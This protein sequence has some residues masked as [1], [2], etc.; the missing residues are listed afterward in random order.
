[1]SATSS[2]RNNR[3]PTAPLGP[4][5]GNRTRRYRLGILFA[6]TSC[7]GAACSF[8]PADD[9]A[10]GTIDQTTL[11]AGSCPSDTGD[12]WGALGSDPVETTSQNQCIDMR[13]AIRNYESAVCG[14]RCNDAHC[15][16]TFSFYG[17]IGGCTDNKHCFNN[18]TDWKCSDKGNWI[19]H[20]SET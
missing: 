10:P 11:A 6:I 4:D 20:C 7:F 19:C 17:D 2:R 1:L 9:V 3:D 13:S 14:Q 12:N 5:G 15:N 8:D 16:G 18:G